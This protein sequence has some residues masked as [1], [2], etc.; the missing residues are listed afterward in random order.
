MSLVA[1]ITAAA[2]RLLHLLAAGSDTLCVLLPC[3]G[4]VTAFC[5]PCFDCDA[6]D[7][8]KKYPGGSSLRLSVLFTAPPSV[9]LAWAGRRTPHLIQ[10]KTFVALH[11]SFS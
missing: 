6:T 7:F 5:W 10:L 11:T 1:S 8:S 9:R 2:R 4:I 3:A